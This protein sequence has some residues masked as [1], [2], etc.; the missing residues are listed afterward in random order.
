MT[1]THH[2]TKLVWDLNKVHES[3]TG[4]NNENGKPQHNID[5]TMV[6]TTSL[7]TNQVDENVSPGNSSNTIGRHLNILSIFHTA[8][9]IPDC[10]G[11][12][13]I[14]NVTTKICIYK[15][16]SEHKNRYSVTLLCRLL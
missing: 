13:K 1:D 11:Y 9:V 3:G 7:Q 14:A 8:E 2:V 15:I 5:T 16:I 10:L 12:R 4:A 6:D